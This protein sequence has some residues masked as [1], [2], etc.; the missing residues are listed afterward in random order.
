MV[1]SHPNSPKDDLAKM[2]I[3]DAMGLRFQPLL[4]LMAA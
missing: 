3:F 2:K 4:P 1:I